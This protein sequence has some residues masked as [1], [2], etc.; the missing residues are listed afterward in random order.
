MELTSWLWTIP[1][2]FFLA[3]L[4]AL[5][6]GSKSDKKS[7]GLAFAFLATLALWDGTVLLAREYG[8]WQ[9]GRVAPAVV[10][11]KVA[12]DADEKSAKPGYRNRYARTRLLIE[13][14]LISNGHRFDDVLVRLLL[15]R[16]LDVWRVQY[17]Y[18]CGRSGFCDRTD[19]VSREVWTDLRIG[20]ALNMRFA[21]T[22]R[23]PGR[24]DPD[25]QWPAGVIKIAIGAILG[26]SAGYLTGRLKPRQK[27]VTVPAV[28]TSVD[29]VTTGGGGWRI[30]YAYFSACGVACESAEVVYVPGLKTGHDCMATY[31]A[32]QPA[33]GSLRLD[34][35]PALNA[36]R[37]QPPAS[38]PTYLDRA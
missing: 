27:F 23:D 31:P 10:V 19:L 6:T 3:V 36:S 26:L 22:I 8:R 15:T 30:G 14:L 24:L 5:I 11:G 18:A 37:T 21:T 17:R 13:F 12:A 32:G 35:R 16:S 34:S 1:F 4:F 9:H 20:Q 7:V 33:L 2:V 25:R 28:V 38:A 29:P